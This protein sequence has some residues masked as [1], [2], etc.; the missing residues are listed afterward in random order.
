MGWLMDLNLHGLLDH[1]QAALN[2]RAT[3]TTEGAIV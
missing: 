1:N 3:A 2:Q